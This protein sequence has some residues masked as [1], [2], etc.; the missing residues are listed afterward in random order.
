MKRNVL[1]YL[2]NTYNFDQ[3]YNSGEW[4]D[5]WMVLICVKYEEMKMSMMSRWEYMG[6]S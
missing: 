1:Q 6:E 3:Q 4:N 2:H 5:V